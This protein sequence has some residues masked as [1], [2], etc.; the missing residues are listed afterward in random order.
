MKQII[1]WL[2]ILITITV[3]LAGCNGLQNFEQQE[4]P[5]MTQSDFV[6]QVS[7]QETTMSG[8]DNGW[9]IGLQMI[10][11]SEYVDNQG[12]KQ[13]GRM[14]RISI[15]NRDLMQADT[16]EVYEGMIFSVGEQR[17]QVIKL[18]PNSSLSSKP[19][20]S[21]GYITLGQLP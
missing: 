11:Q 6:Y 14:A 19:G 7:V 3:S 9:D 20:S 21:N 18:K 12:Q 16:L 8:L 1:G 15:G 13:T 2:I 17:F 5:P 4:T 10:Y